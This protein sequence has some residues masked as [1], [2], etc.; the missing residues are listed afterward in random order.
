MNTGP[1]TLFTG[2]SLGP[3]LTG[4]IRA[5]DDDRVEFFSPSQ[6]GV[7]RAALRFA[8]RSAR[9]LRRWSSGV[10]LLRGRV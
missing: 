7:I 3:G 9:L 4:C 8:W 6:R 10:E 2:P 5:P 1:S